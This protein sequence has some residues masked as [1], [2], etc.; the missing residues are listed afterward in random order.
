MPDEQAVQISIS[1]VRDLLQAEV[2]CGEEHIDDT[3]DGVYASDLMSDVLAYGNAGS[4]MLTGLCTKQAIITA[5]LAL[6]KAIVFIRGKHPSEEMIAFARE[7]KMIVLRTEE[8]MFEVCVRIAT[9]TGSVQATSFQSEH[10]ENKHVTTHEFF[11]EGSDF[12]NSGM[13]STQVKTLLQSIGYDSML[14]RRVAISTYE[15]EM[16]VVMHALRGNVYVTAGD[17]EIN[18]IIEDEG[19]GIPDI[20]KAMQRGFSTATEEQRALGFG[21]GM[22]L[23][24][25]KKSTDDMKITSQ[26]G[27]GTRI[28]TR[29]IVGREHAD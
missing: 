24:N 20:E 21:S 25:I 7:K 11:I 2:L 8:D 18:I 27:K 19:K 29:F 13:V 10:K 3:V 12:A 23:P 4:I 14:I 1:R 5:F 16:N 22:G 9:L 17:R 26:V 6:F 15:A 28:E